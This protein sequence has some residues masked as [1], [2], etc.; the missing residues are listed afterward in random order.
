MGREVDVVKLQ[1]L[2]RDHPGA[3]AD[4][5]IHPAAMPNNLRPLKLVH[6]DLALFLDGLMI[7]AHSHNQVHVLV[8][9][10]ALLEYLGMPEVEHVEHTIRVDAHWVVRILALGQWRHFILFHRA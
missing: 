8:E 1:E 4:H 3:G 7:S 5:L 9:L 10:F 2:R 6:N